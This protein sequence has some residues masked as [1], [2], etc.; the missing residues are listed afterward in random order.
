MRLV[1]ELMWK[2]ET[3]RDT[4]MTRLR[5]FLWRKCQVSVKGDSRSDKM[6]WESVNNAIAGRSILHSPSVNHRKNVNRCFPASW[7]N[8]NS[9]FSLQLWFI[10]FT[11]GAD[12]NVTFI[13]KKV[14]Q[15]IFY[16][17]IA[18][19]LRRKLLNEKYLAK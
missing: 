2:N 18:W 3:I 16:K 13:N 12:I 9:Q 10:T 5:V 6:N 1:W 17:V 19:Y 8:N 15:N 4:I 7:L 14:S 11:I